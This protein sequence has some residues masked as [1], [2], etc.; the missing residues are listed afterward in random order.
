MHNLRKERW[1]YPKRL[2]YRFHHNPSFVPIIKQANLVHASLPTDLKS[3]LILSYH[4]GPGNQSGIFRS[5]FAT[6]SCTLIPLPRACHKHGILLFSISSCRKRIFDDYVPWSSTLTSFTQ[7]P[8]ISSLLSPNILHNTIFFNAVK[9]RSPLSVKDQVS[10][11]YKK[12]QN[13]STLYLM[14]VC[15]CIVAYA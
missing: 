3:V 12:K 10:N 9:I 15:P 4:L 13:N 6:K 8:V 14:C 5:Y 1:T 2:Q 11:P 7:S